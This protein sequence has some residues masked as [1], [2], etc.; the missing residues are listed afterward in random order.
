[1]SS[2]ISASVESA[3]PQNLNLGDGSYIDD[4][5]WLNFSGVQATLQI[6]R[7]SLIGRHNILNIDGHVRIG[8]YCLFGPNVFVTAF[9]HRYEQI[10]IPIIA[11]GCHHFQL[12]IEDNCWLGINTVVRGNLTLGRHTVVGSNSVIV[13]TSPPFS[14]VCGAPA[15]VVKLYDPVTKCWERNLDLAL[16]HREERPVPGR[17][18]YLEL[19]DRSGAGPVSLNFGWW[20]Q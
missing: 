5:T 12:E 8:C 16:R 19:L 11:G 20:K 17:Q 14:V 7:N 3:Y 6:G 2:Y 18:E 15:K 4:F 10:G 9:D 13:E 1:M